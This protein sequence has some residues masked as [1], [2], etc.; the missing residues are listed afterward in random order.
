[1]KKIKKISNKIQEKTNFKLAQYSVLA[2]AALAGVSGCDDEPSP[3]PAPQTTDYYDV[4]PDFTGGIG[5]SFDLDLNYDGIVDFQISAFSNSI[6]YYGYPGQ[7]K[8]ILAYPQNGAEVAGN[9]GVYGYSYA[10]V[11]NAGTLVGSNMNWLNGSYQTLIWSTNIQGSNLGSF[12]VW[13]GTQNDKYLGLKVYDS[14]QAHYGWVRLTT[15]QF[16]TT[17]EVKEYAYE[18]LANEPI[19]T[20]MINRNAIADENITIYTFNKKLII[21]DNKSRDLKVRIKNKEE[22]EIIKKIINK[23]GEI[24]LSEGKYDINIELKDMVITKEISIE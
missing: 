18:T 12:G 5:D 13:T 21:N 7:V 4:D 1:M 9:I 10:G 3:L 20:E 24:K 14:G 2:T 15:N 23:K 6:T 17:F 8:G 11:L 19:M 16:Q 22:K